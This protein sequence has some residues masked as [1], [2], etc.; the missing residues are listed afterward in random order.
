MGKGRDIAIN[1]NNKHYLQFVFSL[2]VFLIISVCCLCIEVEEVKRRQHCL[3]FSSAG[4]QAQTYFVNFDT[5]ADYQRWHRQASK[6][7]RRQRVCVSAV[8]SAHYV[9]SHLFSLLRFVW[10]QFVPLGS[11]LNQGLDVG[12]TVAFCIVCLWCRPI[13]NRLSE[14][15]WLAPQRQTLS[16]VWQWLNNIPRVT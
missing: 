12:T 3:M 8:C 13:R 15:C 14:C 6:V 7:S 1:S 2:P 11:S 5:L 9:S 4:S 10:S 16:G